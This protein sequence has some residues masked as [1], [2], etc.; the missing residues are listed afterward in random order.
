MNDLFQQLHPIAKQQ[1][2]NLQQQQSN[3]KSS[4]PR[5]NNN[6]FL[7]N[8]LNSSNP[9]QF[10]QNMIQSNPQMQNIMK[11]FQSSGMTPK[12]FFYQYAQQNGIDPDQFLSSLTN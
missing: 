7:K 10:I 11:L 6:N 2:E 9:S 1:Q 4:V 3:L 5:L 12:S 8:F